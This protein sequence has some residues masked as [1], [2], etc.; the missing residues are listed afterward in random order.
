MG[1]ENIFFWN[2]C[3]SFTLPSLLASRHAMQRPRQWRA[4]RVLLAPCQWQ[5]Q[6]MEPP[7][8]GAQRRPHRAPWG[9][10]SK[11]AGQAAQSLCVEWSGEWVRTRKRGKERERERE[12]KQ[13]SHH[14]PSS[15]AIC[16]RCGDFTT[17]LRSARHP[18]RCRPAALG[19]LR[20]ARASSGS[21]P[22]AAARAAFSTSRR[23]KLDKA[24]AA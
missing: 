15:N 7:C 16:T 12:K 23:H 14:A 10:L 20:M 2:R 24:A 22:P 8:R 18:L 9:G 5:S 17:R 6:R 19:C 3:Y 21:A 11:L 1:E 13:H 4:M